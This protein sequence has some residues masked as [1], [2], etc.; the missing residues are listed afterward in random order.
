MFFALNDDYL[1][2]GLGA[3]G[4]DVLGSGEAFAA[5]MIDVDVV[6]ALHNQLFEL[7]I[8]LIILYICQ[9]TLENAI[10]NSIAHLF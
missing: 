10:V 4:W 5:E 9:H 6:L 8:H 1:G 2:D 3:L 7:G